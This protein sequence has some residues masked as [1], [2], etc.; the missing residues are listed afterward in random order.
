MIL[1]AETGTPPPQAALP[2][3]ASPQPERYQSAVRGTVSTAAAAHRFWIDTP[4]DSPPSVSSALP[5][6]CELCRLRDIGFTISHRIAQPR[7]VGIERNDARVRGS[8]YG[9]LR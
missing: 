3:D 2:S 5:P 7:T 1:L 8:R 9:I 6:C 4:G